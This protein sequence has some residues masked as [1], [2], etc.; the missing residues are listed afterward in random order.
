MFD[1]ELQGL[2]R[3]GLH[4]GKNP[5]LIPEANSDFVNRAQ[6]A[7]LQ[8][9]CNLPLWWA[10][11]PEWHTFMEHILWQA[12]CWVL[13]EVL[14][15]QPCHLLFD[16]TAEGFPSSQHQTVLAAWL[17]QRVQPPVVCSALPIG[18]LAERRGGEE[19]SFNTGLIP[20]TPLLCGLLS[21]N[22]I[23]LD[24]LQIY[25]HQG[26]LDSH[27]CLSFLFKSSI[28]IRNGY[29]EYNAA[30]ITKWLKIQT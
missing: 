22:H 3:V 1:V 28:F 30:F 11:Q 14:E 5:E 10:R 27:L 15:R 29:L 13:V 2:H 17:R 21:S 16:Y 12:P 24:L 9:W 26:A 8:G 19:R 7:G 4:P 25:L 6:V 20:F 18:C 23:S